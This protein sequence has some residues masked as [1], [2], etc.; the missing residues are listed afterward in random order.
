MEEEKRLQERG[1]EAALA[2][3]DHLKKKGYITKTT[4]DDGTITEQ[5]SEALSNEQAKFLEQDKYKKCEEEDPYN[6]VRSF[7][8]ELRNLQG[9]DFVPPSESTENHPYQSEE[10]DQASA[11]DASTGRS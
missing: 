4:R 3:W 10:V 11:T 8:N 9:R 2:Y 7:N 6:F 5:L 1:V